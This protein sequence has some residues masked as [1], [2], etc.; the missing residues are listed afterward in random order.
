MRR[1]GV[2][3]RELLVVVV[4]LCGAVGV[5]FPTDIGSSRLARQRYECQTNLKQIALAFQQYSQDSD[6]HFPSLRTKAG[7]REAVSP[8]LKND[9]VFQ[10]PGEGK[11]ETV[12][13]SDYWFNARLEEKAEADVA[14]TSQTLLLGDGYASGDPRTA[15]SQMPKIW[16][17]DEDSPAQRHL[18]SANYAFVDGHVKWMRPYRIATQKQKQNIAAFALR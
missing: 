18:G 5:L 12:G 6:G 8:Y 15:L 10:C 2:T 7:W 17:E 11:D 14:V 3:L 16:R 1:K 4:I 13:T 9:N